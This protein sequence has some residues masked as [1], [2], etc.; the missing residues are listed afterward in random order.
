MNK[1]YILAGALILSLLAYFIFANKGTTSSLDSEE[2]AFSLKD[3]ATITKF[4]LVEMVNEKQKSQITLEKNAAGKWRVNNEFNALEP[5]VSLFF[6]TISQLKV[7][8]VLTDKGNETADAILKGYRVRVEFF[9]EKGIMKAYDLGQEGKDHIGSLMRMADAEHSYIVEVPGFQGYLNGR[10]PLLLQAWEEN[11]LFEWDYN[12]IQ[13]VEAK[14]QDKNKASFVLK[15]TEN[16]AFSLNG[17]MADSTKINRYLHQYKGKIYAETFANADFP[18]KKGE[19]DKQTP[20]VTFKILY[21]DGSQKSLVL[22]LR[23]G[24]NNSYFGWI[25][26]ENELLTVQHFVV[27]RFLALENPLMLWKERMKSE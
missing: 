16:N 8:E 11:L 10:F 9:N 12:K 27:N 25:E 2:T 17:K 13:S 1:T 5:Q 18:G 19:L 15:K 6:K 14:F 22:F 3:T 7:R 4:R 23:P 24:N 20:D 21:K 26:G